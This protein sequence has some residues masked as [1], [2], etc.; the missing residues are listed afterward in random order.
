[1][2]K[3]CT[4]FKKLHEK[5][6]NKTARKILPLM[7]VGAMAIS[8]VPFSF[9]DNSVKGLT[10]EIA[11]DYHQILTELVGYSGITPENA[12]GYN[13]GYGNEAGVAHA[14]LI[15]FD[16]DGVPELYTVTMDWDYNANEKVWKWDKSEARTV[17]E[18]THSF[19]SG[20]A[21]RIRKIL[22]SGG[23]YFLSDDEYSFGPGYGAG[24]SHVS[25]TKLGL[26]DGVFKEI[27]SA[28]EVLEG[29]PYKYEL[30]GYSDSSYPDEYEGKTVYE[31]SVVENG[32]ELKS[33]TKIL[34]GGGV[35]PPQGYNKFVKDYISKSGE[36]VEEVIISGAEAN[37]VDVKIND[38]DALLKLLKDASEVKYD[39]PEEINNWSDKDLEELNKFMHKFTYDSDT[40][41]H[42]FDIADSETYVNALFYAVGE[43]GS[44]SQTDY[45]L[46]SSVSEVNSKLKE[47]FDG[48]INSQDILS[49]SRSNRGM[50]ISNGKITTNFEMGGRGYVTVFTQ[51][52]KIHPI[53]EDVYL[54][55]AKSGMHSDGDYYY[56]TYEW[57]IIEN[58]LIDGR[59][60]L[61]SPDRLWSERAVS[62]IFSEQTQH[63]FIVKKTEDGYRLMRF[64]DKPIP[65]VDS[66]KKY[67]SSQKE[68]SNFVFDYEKTKSYK[69]A[70]DYINALKDIL[71]G[72]KGEKI[73]DAGTSDLIKYAEYAITNS[74]PGLVKA[75]KNAITVDG[76]AVKSVVQSATDTKNQISLLLDDHKVN[77]TKDIAV[78]IRVDSGSLNFKKP[79]QVTFKEDILKEIEAANSVSINLGDGG[80]RVF[81]DTEDLK[82]I[83]NVIIQINKV[84]DEGYDITFM[85]E[86]GKTI[87][88]LKG[89]IG[90][91]LPASGELS[92]VYADYKGGSDNWGG[93]Y[94]FLNE[95]I[96]FK[97]PYSGRYTVLDKRIKI[98][99]IDDLDED[100]QRG[101]QF[102]VSK[103]Y[104]T[105]DDEDRFLPYDTLT[106]YDFSA[107]LVKIF[108]A[109]DREL[110][111]TFEDVPKDSEYYPYVAS[112]Q[113][114][115]I[116]Q[117]YSDTVFGGDDNI[118]RVQMIALCARTLAEKKGYE[119]P[120]NPEDYLNFFDMELI[121][122]WAIDDVALAVR[123]GLIDEGGIFAPENEISRGDA[124]L[125]L[126]RLFMLLYEV[127]PGEII[128]DKGSAAGNIPI[129]PM[130]LGAGAIGVGVGIGLYIKKRRK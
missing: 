5:N 52:E 70:A 1:M 88:K 40:N 129:V 89:Q 48:N 36:V 122:E 124:A 14:R 64:Q 46:Y 27:A 61:H 6:K 41:L 47:L 7:L 107:A 75:K 111:T 114:A 19:Y 96:E 77:L 69:K 12:M 103:G 108:Y 20:M 95:N 121:P 25:F 76:K 59:H 2:V 68:K 100:M 4:L 78:N 35:E 110:T 54:V 50:K 62:S 130:A 126:H 57:G 51:A 97:T 23:K 42:R 63:Y 17:F 85:D 26:V 82:K 56:L 98:A 84:E 80:H 125:I 33:E 117:G 45:T 9:A 53:S 104:F 72:L 65:V 113:E 73:N 102:M 21:N 116:I 105:L 93:Q 11:A 24:S 92:T 31:Y 18:D 39:I 86:S 112:G 99:D 37:M 128:V 123:E 101:I 30:D 58:D 90:F 119:Y 91:A 8:S 81:A 49:Y 22:K 16:G 10:P 115:S 28:R 71:S 109:L 118:Q 120:D 29:Y 79:I 55:V 60:T 83:G 34:P 43:T 15:D 106:R 87:E 127:S 94:D 3:I 13:K 32:R 38:I 44:M 66:L 74:K 67:K